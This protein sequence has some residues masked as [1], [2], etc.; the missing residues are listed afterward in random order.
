MNKKV[1]QDVEIAGT[2]SASE[3]EITGGGT[4]GDNLKAVIKQYVNTFRYQ[5]KEYYFS[6]DPTSPAVT[7]GGT[8]ERVE[9]RVIMGA[10][11]AYPAGTTG[12]SADA[13]VG[14]HYHSGLYYNAV[15]D[16]RRI[17]PED[18]QGTTVTNGGYMG[19]TSHVQGSAQFVTGSAGESVSGKNLSP[20]RAAYIW[21]KIS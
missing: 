2:V 19:L 10:S 4:L 7:Y 20:Y 5:G 21:R 13:V 14:E 11:D 9:G 8:W 18:Y 17:S 3:L 15:T 12:G 1:Y 16:D 6:D